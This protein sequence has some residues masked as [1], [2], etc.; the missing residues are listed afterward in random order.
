MLYEVITLLLVLTASALFGVQLL[1][2][3]DPLSIFLRSLTLS[4]YPAGNLAA[5]GLFQY[6]YDHRVP[7][8]SSALDRAYVIT[9]YSLHYPK[10][11]ECSEGLHRKENG[12][13]SFQTTGELRSRGNREKKLGR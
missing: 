9:S 1:G 2:L 6:F 3:F 4:L 11:Y 13:E 12:T 5:N 7:V 8:V 10:L